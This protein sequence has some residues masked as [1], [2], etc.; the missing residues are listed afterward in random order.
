MKRKFKQATL[1]KLENNPAEVKRM[2]ASKEIDA[3]GANRQRLH[4]P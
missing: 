4:Q 3:F 2:L 1:I